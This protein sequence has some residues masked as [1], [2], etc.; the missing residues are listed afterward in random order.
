MSELRAPD[1]TLTAVD[2]AVVVA[3]GGEP[4]VAHRFDDDDPFSGLRCDAP[5][6]GDAHC[7]ASRDARWF[8]LPCRECFPDAPPPGHEF[9][10]L[11][12]QDN[13]CTQEVRRIGG[14][15]WQVAR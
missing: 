11:I 2:E 10:T 5:Y 4:P 1:P 14:L 13:S 12:H 6:G 7:L 8:A 3:I 15:A 9:Y